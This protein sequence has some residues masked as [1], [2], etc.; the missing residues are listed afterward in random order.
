MHAVA[1]TH[2]NLHFEVRLE[3]LEEREEDGER[4]F[5]HLWDARGSVLRESDAEVLLHCS[6]EHLLCLE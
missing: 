2:F 3:G 5:H 6:D 4:E 1:Q